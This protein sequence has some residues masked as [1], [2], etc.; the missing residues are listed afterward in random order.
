M[1]HEKQLR[2]RFFGAKRSGFVTYRHH[3]MQ[4]AKLQLVVKYCFWLVMFYPIKIC[5]EI[6]CL[7]RG[8][9]YTKQLLAFNPLISNAYLHL[10]GTEEAMCRSEQSNNVCFDVHNP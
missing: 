9:W 6:L 3:V 2:S 10:F 1:Y 5:S 7:Y 8:Y 4:Q